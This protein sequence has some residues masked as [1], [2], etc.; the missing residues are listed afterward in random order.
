MFHY[1]AYG[2]V[3]LLFAPWREHSRSIL[4]FAKLRVLLLLDGGFHHLV[5]SYSGSRCSTS[6]SWHPGR[7]ARPGETLSVLPSAANFCRK[8]PKA[9]R[10]ST[11]RG[12]HCSARH[13][14]R[15]D[16]KA[17][18]ARRRDVRRCRLA[19][20]AALRAE[21]LRVRRR[22]A[23]E[24]PSPLAGMGGSRTKCAAVACERGSKD[25]APPRGGAAAAAGARAAWQRAAR[26]FGPLVCTGARTHLH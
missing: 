9:Q 2:F 3:Y 6:T 5:A 22:C 14:E 23:V 15:G 7:E 10:L 25:P 21:R 18:K 8:A 19:A 12:R 4:W 17:P 1:D 24:P 16:A 11:S 20:A 13:E 26:R